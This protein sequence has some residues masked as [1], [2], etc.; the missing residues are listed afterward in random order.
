MM[1]GLSSGVDEGSDRI[2]AENGLTQG[3]G[4]ASAAPETKEPA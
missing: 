4:G 2:V 1:P 3:A